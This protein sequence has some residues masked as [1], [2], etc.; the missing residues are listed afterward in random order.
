MDQVERKR[1]EAEKFWSVQLAR[2]TACVYEGSWIVKGTE[3]VSS[4]EIEC[5]KWRETGG[6]DNKK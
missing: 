6:I 5:E 2:M 1:R 3:K 4:A